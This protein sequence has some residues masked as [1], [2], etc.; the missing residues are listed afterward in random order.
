MFLGVFRE[1]PD[2]YLR[3]CMIKIDFFTKVCYN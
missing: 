1:K 2:V 3:K